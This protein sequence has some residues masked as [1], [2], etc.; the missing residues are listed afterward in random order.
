MRQGEGRRDLLTRLEVLEAPLLD[1]I[2]VECGD[3]IGESAGVLEEL[4]YGDL[5]AVVA[6]RADQTGQVVLHRGVQRDTSFGGELEHHRR[7]EGLGGA[8]DPDPFVAAH[9]PAGPHVGQSA[10]ARP[11]PAGRVVHLRGRSRHAVLPGQRVQ[12]PLKTRMSA[13]CA[14]PLRHVAGASAGA[15]GNGAGQ[16]QGQPGP[17]HRQSAAH[18]IFPTKRTISHDARGSR[19]GGHGHWRGL[20]SQD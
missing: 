4:P 7:G 6:V 5:S 15:G 13:A 12:F 16:R 2:P 20:Q 1:V 8:A 18:A 9:R 19:D 17:G 10:G 11:P 3:V 14:R